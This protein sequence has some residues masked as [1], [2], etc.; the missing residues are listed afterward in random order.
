[1]ITHSTSG[2][3][4]L[5]SLS[6]SRPE[7]PGIMRSTSMTSGSFFSRWASAC[8]PSSSC[9]TSNPFWASVRA[10]VRRSVGSSS[11][12]T[13]RGASLIDLG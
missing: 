12:T 13:T 11:T 10:I 2:L 8:V 1:M 3:R 9:V 6:T 4:A 5:V 7:T